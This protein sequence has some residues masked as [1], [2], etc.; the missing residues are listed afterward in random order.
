MKTGTVRSAMVAGAA[1]ISVGLTGCGGTDELPGAE[2]LEGDPLVIGVIMD[3][4]GTASFYSEQAVE[5]IEYAA[6]ATNTGEFPVAL[7]G[8]FGEGSRGILDRPVKIV[9]EDDGS[10]PNRAVQAARKLIAA[11]AEAIISTSGSAS[12]LQ[13]RIVCEEE[14]IPCIAPYSSSGAIVQQPNAGYMFTIAPNST[15]QG[16]SFSGIFKENGYETYAIV[17]DSSP[18]SA[19]VADLYKAAFDDAG[20]QMVAREVVPVGSTDATA[21]VS[22]VRSANPDVVFDSFAALSEEG[23]FY[24]SAGDS[25]DGIARWG[26]NGLITSDEPAK[27]AGP[28][29]EGVKTLDVR[30]I[31][32]AYG[33]EVQDAFE[34]AHPD[35]DYLSWTTICNW[36]AFMVLK[37]AFEEV[38]ST[39]GPDVVAEIEGLKDFPSVLGPPGY[40][41]SFSAD[42]HNG[43]SSKALVPVVLEADGSIALADDET[44]PD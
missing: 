4:S 5:M 32:N 6:E 22:R 9:T 31:E 25:L 44:I 2:G 28:D 12:A 42:N 40:T 35:I 41:T 18:T 19:A 11:G 8:L 14:K 20:L 10:D 36:E 1:L 30:S 16:A 7:Q 29:I 33:V 34:K 13:S 37:H 21:Q 43:S 39:D 15:V 17:G 38:G 27:V 23:L 24:K 26:N 3:T